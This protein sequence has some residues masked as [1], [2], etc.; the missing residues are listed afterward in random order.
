MRPYLYQGHAKSLADGSPP[1]QV[2]DSRMNTRRSLEN[3]SAKPIAFLHHMPAWLAPMVITGLFVAGAF[4][5]GWIGAVA[6]CLVAAFIAWLGRPSLAGVCPPGRLLRI[7]IIALL[8]V[9]ALWQAS[10]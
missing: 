3:A 2:E 10:R 4:A 8:L 9:F 6:L 7:A 1:V 5:A